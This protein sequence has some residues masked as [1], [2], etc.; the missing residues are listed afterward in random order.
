MFGLYGVLLIGM[1]AAGLGI[2]IYWRW[3]VP[4][5]RKRDV[6][7]GEL[8]LICSAKLM[9][10]FEAAIG[11]LAVSLLGCLFGLFRFAP[12]LH[13]ETRQQRQG[14]Q[15]RCAEVIIVMTLVSLATFIVGLI[16]LVESA[17]EENCDD[18]ANGALAVSVLSLSIGPFVSIFHFSFELLLTTTTIAPP[19]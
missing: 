3:E 13:H 7:D 1:L 12:R 10:F 2:A 4:K 18:P 8:P 17:T 9:E 15:T 14:P 5:L 6:P 11:V 19:R 16:G